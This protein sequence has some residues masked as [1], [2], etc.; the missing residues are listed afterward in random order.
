[1]NMSNHTGSERE[2]SPLL[3]PGTPSDYAIS[4]ASSSGTPIPQVQSECALAE[5]SSTKEMSPMD[6]DDD[7]DM[8]PGHDC[9]NEEMPKCPIYAPE[10]RIVKNGIH[11]IAELLHEPLSASSY[12]DGN[13]EGL[14][15][16]LKKRRK[17][18]FPEQVRVALVGDM[19]AGK[20]SLV[21]SLLG[22]GVLARKAG[23]PTMGNG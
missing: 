6:G 11:K 2:T 18:R 10:Y 8:I 16:E 3:E 5:T 9:S 21:N 7:E 1:M 12:T 20:S 4:S 15:Q 23:A 17:A 13:V 14:K 22:V 19:A